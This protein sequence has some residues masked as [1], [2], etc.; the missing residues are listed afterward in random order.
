MGAAEYD[1]A[2]CIANRPPVPPYERMKAL[3]P[4]KRGDI[5]RVVAQTGNHWR[6]V[7]NLYAK[8]GFALDPAGFSSWQ[9]YRDGLLLSAQSRQALLFDG[10][11][12]RSGCV[13]IVSGKT[14]A[15]KLG[16]MAGAAP[17]Q[18]GFFRQRE[19]RL[20][21]S[22][23]FDYRQLSNA[24]LARLQELVRDCRRG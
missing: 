11:P 20:I 10:L 6:K 24:R 12:R 8:L 2:V 9:D 7:F 16:V 21:V 5:E 15:E 13:T 4:L 22:P 18:D 19:A 23:Y 14:H 1:L 3:R 17:L